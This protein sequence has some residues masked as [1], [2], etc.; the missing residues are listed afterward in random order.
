MAFEI[1]ED[2]KESLTKLVN[3]YLPK[4]EFFFKEDIYGKTRFLFIK[5]Q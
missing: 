2:M 1:G 4:D 5:H 3:V